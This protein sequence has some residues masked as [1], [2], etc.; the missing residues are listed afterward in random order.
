MSKICKEALPVESVLVLGGNHGI[1]GF[2]VCGRGL[3]A[4]REFLNDWSCE[5]CTDILLDLSKN[6]V[7]SA[8]PAKNVARLLDG[9]RFGD[10]HIEMQEILL[11]KRSSS[12]HEGIL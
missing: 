5:R 3:M 11:H 7:V 1:M 9:W 4:G 10:G 12:N 8:T 6:Y 2:D